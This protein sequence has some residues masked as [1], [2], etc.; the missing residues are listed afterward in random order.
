MDI[1]CIIYLNNILI[2]FNSIEKYKKYIIQILKKLQI[3]KLYI[4]ILK[5]KFYKEKI[6]FFEFFV[7]K[8]RIEIDFNYIKTI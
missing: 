1:C 7:G 4:K 3:Y 6:K 2:F 8:N 5:Y